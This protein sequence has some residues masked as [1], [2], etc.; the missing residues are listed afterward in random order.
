MVGRISVMSTVNYFGEHT[1][2]RAVAAYFAKHGV[3]EE[4]RDQLI[5]MESEDSEDF[6][7]MVSDFVECHA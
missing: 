4:V 1:V 6:F 3:T 2:E 7:S 5:K